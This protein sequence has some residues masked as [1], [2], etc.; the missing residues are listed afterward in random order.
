MN[1]A[2]YETM[3][4]VEERHWWF[5]ALHSLILDTLTRAVPHWHGC[6]ILDAGCGTGAILARLGRTDDRVGI[7]LA[8]EGI[9]FCRKRGLKT[10]VRGD[11][12]S[13][14]F[15]NE[16]FDAII[17]S[18]VLYHQWVGDVDQALREF[19]RVLR[20]GGVLI[21]NLPAYRFLHSPHDE[22][23]MTARRFTRPEVRSALDQAGFEIRRITY[24]TTLLFPLAFVA[25]TLGG[26]S[27]GRDFE[28]GRVTNAILGAVMTGERFLLG[29][30]SLPFGVAILAVARKPQ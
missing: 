16:S 3:F 20:P 10:V 18:S 29:L 5:R 25:R 23:V 11:V 9:A 4:R 28:A 30:V 17:C 1:A 13:L 7:D 14:P 27:Q 21:L 8:D 26:S 24:W 15:P 22:A 6:K 2:E 19:F 12:M